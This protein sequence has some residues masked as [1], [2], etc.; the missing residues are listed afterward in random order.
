MKS[1]MCFTLILDDLA[2]DDYKKGVFRRLGVEVLNP[3]SSTTVNV[4]IILLISMKYT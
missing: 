4:R 3:E 2:P 1:Y